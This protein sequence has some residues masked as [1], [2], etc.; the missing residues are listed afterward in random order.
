MIARILPSDVYAEECFD[1]PDGPPLFP[2][3][4]ALIAKAV[5]KRRREFT[6]V[7]RCARR[8]L[9]R[10]GVPPVPLLPGER[11]AP[12]WPPGVVGSMTHCTGY[13]A[14]VVADADRVLTL[15]IDA[16][17]A[18]P[19]PEGV[20]EAVASETERKRL[21]DLAA[22][23]PDI[24]WDRLL[25]SAKESVYKAWFPLTTRWLDFAEADVDFDPAAGTFAARL[26]IADRPL[27]GFA[28][29]WQV[30]AG[31][32]LTAIVVAKAG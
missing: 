26:L 11:G 14:A 4:E 8:A 7:R 24:P 9:G 16:E 21:L 30:D 18:L 22:D 29:R 17:P 25:F 3:E 2:A 1:D 5:D 6:T 20:L 13:R 28:G 31:I 23:R 10:L 27:D 15:G 19:L 32:A 12:G